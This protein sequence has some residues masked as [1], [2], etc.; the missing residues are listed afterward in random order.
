MRSFHIPFVKGFM[1]GG[2]ADSGHEPVVGQ[3]N[4]HAIKAVHQPI[5]HYFAAPA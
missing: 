5:E 2:F 4:H 3:S 1:A